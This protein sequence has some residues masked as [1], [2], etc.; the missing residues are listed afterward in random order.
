MCYVLRDLQNMKV[1]EIDVV[2]V[3]T[4]VKILMH[5][6]VNTMSFLFAGDAI[7][8]IKSVGTCSHPAWRN[9]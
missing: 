7:L 1:Q 5:I 8:Q 9:I 2:F 4:F 3:Q 6:W